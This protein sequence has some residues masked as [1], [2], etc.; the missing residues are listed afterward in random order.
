MV[1]EITKA[2]DIA[3]IRQFYVEFDCCVRH[4]LQEIPTY[5][6]TPSGVISSPTTP[7]QIIID[8]LDTAACRKKRTVRV[9]IRY[10]VYISIYSSAY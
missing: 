4:R 6:S 8:E 9:R 2:L 1:V 7:L 3:R 5:V 10:Y